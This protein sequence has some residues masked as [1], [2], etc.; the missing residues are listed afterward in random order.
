MAPA[1]GSGR[2]ATPIGVVDAEAVMNGL[3]ANDRFAE[4]RE[5]ASGPTRKCGSSSKSPITG[6]ERKT[7]A[8]SEVLPFLTD[9]VDKGAGDL[10]SGPAGPVR[11]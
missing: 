4:A 9:A 7:F 10:E 2:A 8:R 11:L 6:V 5:S 1:E 3:R